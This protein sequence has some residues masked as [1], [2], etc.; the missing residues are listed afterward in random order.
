MTSQWVIPV[1]PTK[2][3]GIV[4]PRGRLIAKVVKMDEVIAELRER[5]L[6]GELKADDDHF[7]GGSAPLT[8]EQMGAAESELDFRLPVFLRR[9]YTEVANG[10]FGPSYGLLGLKGGMLNE[11]KCDAVAQYVGYRELDPSDPHWRW[12]KALLPVGHLGCAMY[13]CVDCVKPDGPVTWFEP[14]PHEDG[15]SWDDSF[16]PFADSTLDWIAA[17]VRGEDLFDRL[18]KD[19]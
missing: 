12:P 4:A 6:R 5:A 18:F 1:A 9:I 7:K 19:G 11:E 10:G 15:E 2:A 17:W 16:I 8:E 3:T 13:L 14:N